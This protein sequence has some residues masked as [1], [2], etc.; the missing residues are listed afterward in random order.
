MWHA[1]R[2]MGSAPV[3]EIVAA[4]N[5]RDHLRALVPLDH[6]VIDATD[7]ARAF[8]VEQILAEGHADLYDAWLILGRLLAVR[9]G[10]PTL[11]AGTLDGALA[12]L[13]PAERD[14]AEGTWAA[15]ARAALAEGFDAGRMEAAR[16]EA[17]ATWDF[18]RCAVRVDDATTAFAA[19]P[20]DDDADAVSAWAARTALAAQRARVRRAIIDGPDAPRRA[21]ADALSLAGIEL[22]V[23]GDGAR[24]PRASWLPWRRRGAR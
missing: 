1:D 6:A 8:V 17:L 20:P 22:V 10:S 23:R 4:W 14:G 13:P 16:G 9:G 7:G 5:A 21:L 3:D 11:A 18:P 2:R 19:A 24:A 12:A 15:S